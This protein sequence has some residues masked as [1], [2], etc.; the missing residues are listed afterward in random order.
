MLQNIKTLLIAPAVLGGI[1]SAIVTFPIS[2]VSAFFGALTT[3]VTAINELRVVNGGASKKIAEQPSVPSSGLSA[4]LLEKLR[5]PGFCPLAHAVCNIYAALTALIELHLAKSFIMVVFAIAGIAVARIANLGYVPQHRHPSSL[6]KMGELAWRMLTQNLQVVLKDPGLLF[7][8]G[9]VSLILVDLRFAELKGAGIAPI[10]FLLGLGL[11]I[12]AVVK[13]IQ[14]LL[15]YNTAS[16]S[17]SASLIGGV[18]DLFLGY[19]SFFYGNTFTAIG[20]IFWGL[21]NICLGA[22]VGNTQFDRWVVM[23]WL[24]GEK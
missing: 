2:R 24:R 5:S 17:G 8:L 13:G 12:I 23:R 10:F 4:F 9:N 20:T 1:G 3:V 18:S 6:E 15:R 22:R 14:P 19:S 16:A 11:A 7:C 21:S